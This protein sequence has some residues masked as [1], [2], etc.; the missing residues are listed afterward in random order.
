MKRLV[1]LICTLAILLSVV[2]PVSADNSQITAYD[3]EIALAK[4]FDSME[5]VSVELQKTSDYT[6]HK[7]NFPSIPQLTETTNS[8]IKASD[9]MDSIVAT[10]CQEN[11]QVLKK[12]ISSLN[13]TDQEKSI[14]IRS[15]EEA[16]ANNDGY[17][18]EYKIY[19]PSKRAS[20]YEKY[21]TYS[22]MTFYQQPSSEISLNYKKMAERNTSILNNWISMAKDLVLTCES[23]QPISMMITVLSMGQRMHSDNYSA[24]SGDYT[25]YYV[26]TV[27]RLRNIGIIDPFGDFRIV[28][29]DSKTDVYPYSIYYFADPSIYNTS[30]SVSEYVNDW[31]TIY[32]QYYNNTSYNLQAAYKQYTQKPDLILYMQGPNINSTMFKWEWK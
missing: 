14:H 29:V 24:R 4:Q 17:V 10:Q 7:I 28:M 9:D 19:T 32:S 22:G 16:V 21:G 5:N 30:A 20:N 13:L 15:I 11:V 27:Q 31:R 8:H 3:S 1:S 18:D 26:R 6:V 12:Y 23:F 25:E 2:V